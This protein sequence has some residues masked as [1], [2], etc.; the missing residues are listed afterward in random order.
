M[1]PPYRQAAIEAASHRGR[2]LEARGL[3]ARVHLH[4]PGKAPEVFTY[5]AQ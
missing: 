3:S 1:R 2:E 5:P 4:L